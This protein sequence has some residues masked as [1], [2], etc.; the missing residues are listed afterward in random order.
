MQGLFKNPLV[1]ALLGS[2]LLNGVLIG[3]TLSGKQAPDRPV[4]ERPDMRPRGGQARLENLPRHLSPEQRLKFDVAA[5]SS[6][7]DDVRAAFRELRASRKTVLDLAQADPLD[8][9]ALR[10]A[11]KDARAKTDRLSELS[12]KAITAWL[13]SADAQE[14]RDAIKAMKRA[15]RGKGKRGGGPKG[16]RGERR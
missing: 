1:L 10:A 3:K 5:K 14:R 15:G 7:R 11:M 16:E 8:A 4:A 13:L 6:G 12:D 2:V 9:D